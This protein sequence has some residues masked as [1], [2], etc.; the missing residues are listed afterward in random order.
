M[1]VPKWVAKAMSIRCQ[2]QLGGMLNYYYG[3]AAK[4]PGSQLGRHL[5]TSKPLPGKR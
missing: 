5:M 1:S 4:R 2:K 3:E